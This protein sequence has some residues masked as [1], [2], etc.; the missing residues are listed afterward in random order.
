MQKEIIADKMKDKIVDDGG[1]RQEQPTTKKARLSIVNEIPRKEKQKSP[2]CDFRPPPLVLDLDADLNRTI[3]FDTGSTRR[4]VV[5]DHQIAEGGFGAIF[6]A[7]DAT[8]ANKKRKHIETAPADCSTNSTS[9]HPMTYALKRIDCCNIHGQTDQEKIDMCSR[10]ASLHTTFHHKNLMKIFGI[11][12]TSEEKT[13]TSSTIKTCYMLFPYIPTSIRN[14]I[15]KRRLLE[16]TEESNRRPYSEIEALDLFA[17][18]CDGVRTLHEYG[19]SHR[20]L[21]VENVLL[22]E[23]HD[24]TKTPVITDFGSVGPVALPLTSSTTV[25]Q[26]QEAVE[27]YTS[28]EYRAPEL[29]EPKL[30]PY[31]PKENLNYGKSDVWALGCVFFAMLYGSSP[32]EIE[33]G[34][35]FVGDPAD[36]TARLTICTKDLIRR[37][38]PFPPGGS[39]AERRFGESFRELIECMLNHDRFERLSSENVAGRVQKMLEQAQK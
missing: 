12:F 21:K 31:G 30:L 18:I 35:S 20:D 7:R 1:G 15:S 14:D 37:E 5:V 27:K 33:W 28:I 9:S 3:T 17:G 22:E 25:L 26:V 16:D 19:Y 29:L 11:Q 13:K 38:I 10:E 32:F 6:V 2:C 8:S 36:G 24:G 4:T 34:I 23:C 39:A